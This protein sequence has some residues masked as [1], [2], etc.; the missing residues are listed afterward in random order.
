[1]YQVNT[2]SWHITQLDLPVC[3][4]VLVVMGAECLKKVAGEGEEK[5]SS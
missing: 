1:M 5:E 3:D 2:Q 4:N